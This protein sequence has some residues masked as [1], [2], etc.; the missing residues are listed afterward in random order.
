MPHSGAGTDGDE[1]KNAIF[2][3]LRG[4]GGDTEECDFTPGTCAAKVARVL[5]SA[6][7]RKRI[8]NVGWLAAF[9]PHSQR[10]DA[11]HT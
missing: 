3:Q 8:I 10:L 2:L 9:G 4:D 5:T 11:S 7:G 1:K 6:R